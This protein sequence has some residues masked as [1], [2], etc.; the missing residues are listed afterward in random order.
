MAHGVYVYR[1]SIASRGK[2][3]LNRTE[4]IHL[5]RLHRNMIPNNNIISRANE[6]LRHFAIFL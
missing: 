3:A 5:C 4:I 1:T 6:T 2:K